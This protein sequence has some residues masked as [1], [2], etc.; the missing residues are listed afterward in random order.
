VTDTAELEAVC[1]AGMLHDVGKMFVPEE[2][3]NKSGS[4]ADREWAMLRDHP[5]RGYDHLKAQGITD[6]VVLRVTLEH[7]ERVDGTGYPNKITGSQMH[8][9]SQVCAVVDS[10]DAM[11]ACRPFKNRVKTV[12]E[13]VG[14]LQSETPGKYDAEVVKAWV[15]LL[16]QAS[17]DGMLSEPVEE[18]KR[19]PGLGRR[20]HERHAVECAAKIYPVRRAEQVEGLGGGQRGMVHNISLGGLGLLVSKEIPPST[21]VR[22][23]L[24]GKGTLEGAV[25][26]GQVVRCRAYRDGQFDVGVRKCEASAD[27]A[28]AQRAVEQK[29]H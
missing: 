10:F 2:V 19:E 24:D 12:A 20:A 17:N 14:I 16:K 3:L 6:E 27:A 18:V 7:H 11:T 13:A 5:K 8:R 9:I 29:T 1:M 23:A 22:V 15:G 28:A 26:E 25:V 4:L 21:Y